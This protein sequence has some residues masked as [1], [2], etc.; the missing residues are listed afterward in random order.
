MKSTSLILIFFTTIL[1]SSCLSK[2]AEE[3]F[4]ADPCTITAATYSGEVL[5]IIRSNCYRCHDNSTRF[6]GVFLESY[7][8]VA[9]YAKSGALIGVLRGTNGYPIMPNDGAA[10]LEC[11]ILKIEQWVSEGSENN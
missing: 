8:D 2:N 3:D 7:V 4:P 6:G 1:I 10:M 5:P 9:A 11:D